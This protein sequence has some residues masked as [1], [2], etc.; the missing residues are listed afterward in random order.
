MEEAMRRTFSAHYPL[1]SHDEYCIFSK[2]LGILF[3]RF[4]SIGRSVEIFEEFLVFRVKLNSR[5][6][7]RRMGV[8]LV[9]Y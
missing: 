8:H 5:R 9:L 6:I 4:C 3:V 1:G 7:L 2:A